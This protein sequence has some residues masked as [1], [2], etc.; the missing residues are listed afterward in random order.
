M[1]VKLS[2]LNVYISHLHN[3]S[4][5]RIL[6]HSQVQDIEALPKEYQNKIRRQFLN[7]KQ[8]NPG[9]KKKQVTLDFF[10]I[11][12]GAQLVQAISKHMG[13]PKQARGLIKVMGEKKAWQWIQDELHNRKAGVNTSETSPTILQV[14]KQPEIQPLQP[15]RSLLGFESFSLVRETIEEAVLEGGQ[16]TLLDLIL[17]YAQALI[18]EDSLWMLQQLLRYVERRFVDVD[19]FMSLVQEDVSQTL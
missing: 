2:V 8:S 1:Y 11:P 13:D 5:I 7:K 6:T 10:T 12:K 15:S 4:N 3:S 16:A 19:V 9:K 18:E 14:A 17:P